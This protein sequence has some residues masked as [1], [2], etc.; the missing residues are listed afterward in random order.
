VNTKNPDKDLYEVLMD[1]DEMSEDESVGDLEGSD[2][3]PEA[4]EDEDYDFDDMINDEDDDE[5]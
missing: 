2:P 3:D 1:H 5:E 4:I